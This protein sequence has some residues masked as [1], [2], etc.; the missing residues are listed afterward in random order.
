MTALRLCLDI[1]IPFP[2]NKPINSK[3]KASKLKSTWGSYIGYLE[4]FTEN[5]LK[6]SIIYIIIKN[7]DFIR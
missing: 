1:K 5:I 6:P 7:I 4:I 2:T 3:F